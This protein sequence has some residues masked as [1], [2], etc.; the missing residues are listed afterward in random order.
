MTDGSEIINWVCESCGGAARAPR[1]ALCATCLARVRKLTAAADAAPAN[2]G[3]GAY[4]F[5]IRLWAV[6]DP[7]GAP[8]GPFWDTETQAKASVRPDWES[9]AG[10]G[11][12]T[13]KVT[14]MD[15]W[16]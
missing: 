10:V 5:P 12:T 4:R 14:V 15:G 7:E 8:F 2:G 16:L 1:T 11:F 9:C 6:F 13:R 3:G